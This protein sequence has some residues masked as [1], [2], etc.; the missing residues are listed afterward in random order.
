VSESISQ[1]HIKKVALFR[2]DARI[3]LFLCCPGQGWLYGG[4]SSRVPFLVGL[5]V[6]KDIRKFIQGKHH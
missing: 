6:I 2:V 4:R 3:G 5:D 1:I